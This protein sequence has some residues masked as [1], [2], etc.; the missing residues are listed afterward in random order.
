MITCLLAW[1]YGVFWSGCVPGV[2]IAD[3][4]IIK[5]V[6]DCCSKLWKH[7]IIAHFSWKSMRDNMVDVRQ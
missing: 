3:K 6:R 2:A 1:V 4:E 5:Y 7:K